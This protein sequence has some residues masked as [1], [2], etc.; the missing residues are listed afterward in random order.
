MLLTRS[1]N[2]EA[3]NGHSHCIVDVDVLELALELMVSILEVKEKAHM[4][5]A[6][7]HKKTTL[8]LIQMHTSSRE[9]TNEI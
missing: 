5:A 3:E 4:I 8:W 6:A 9:Q 1:I 7:S 2:R